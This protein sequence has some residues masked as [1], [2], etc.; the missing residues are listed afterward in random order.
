METIAA[1]LFLTSIIIFILGMIRPSLFKSIL[2]DRSNRKVIAALSVGIFIFSLVAL[3]GKDNVQSSEN[4]DTSKKEVSVPTE[5]PT[6][7]PTINKKKALKEYADSVVSISLLLNDANTNMIEASQY[8][9]EYDF[10]MS[11]ASMEIAAAKMINIE[12]KVDDLPD[13]EETSELKSHLQAAV[14]IFQKGILKMR[15]GIE[16][17]DADKI[18]EGGEIYSSGTEYIYKA[19]DEMEKITAIYEK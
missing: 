8:G 1:L 10:S 16:E 13:Y 9:A 14:D 2:K 19:T 6:Q 7:V 18:L 4:T 11:K 17:V 12:R 15:Q 5:K 3:P